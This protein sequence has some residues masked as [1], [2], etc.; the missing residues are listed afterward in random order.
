MGR[1]EFI[2]ACM[3]G[4]VVVSISAARAVE[5]EQAAWV[6]VASQELMRAARAKF[7]SVV[8]WSMEPLNVGKVEIEESSP[9]AMHV[10]QIGPRSSVRLDWSFPG[11]HRKSKTIWFDLVGKQ[12]VIVAA[13]DVAI[14][15][16][17]AQSDLRVEHR[18]VLALGCSAMTMPP[19]IPA[20]RARRSVRSGGIVCREYIEA[21]PA[22]ARGDECIVRYV[23]ERV[24]LTT[25]GIAQQDAEIGSRTRVV[26]PISKEVFT[27]VVT[28]NREVIVND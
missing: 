20:I 27:A 7:P 14:G 4:T 10:T 9:A 15:D 22:V 25:R 2:I 23:S 6:D 21:R 8:E 24:S 19:E 17:V 11:T 16:S 3:V 28:A 1:T 12:P 18:D 13:R 26:N 5:S